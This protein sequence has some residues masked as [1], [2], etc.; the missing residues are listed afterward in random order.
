MVG[1]RGRNN[2]ERDA[3]SLKP[4]HIVI[5]AMVLMVIFVLAIVTIATMVVGKYAR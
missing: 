3:V 1:I 2:H 4:L 5:T